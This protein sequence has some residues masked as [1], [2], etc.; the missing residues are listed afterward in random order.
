[1]SQSSRYNYKSYKPQ[2][3]GDDVYSSG[4]DCH[5]PFPMKSVVLD[6]L[7]RRVNLK[8]R[9][10]GK[11]IVL[12]T[13]SLTCP[14]YVANIEAMNS[15]ADDFPEICFIVLYVR[16]EN[17]GDVIPSVASME[18]KHDRAFFLEKLED[19]RRQIFADGLQGNLHKQ[20][21]TYPNLVYVI[22]P[23]GNVEYKRL[24]NKPGELRSHLEGSVMHRNQR[25]DE[26]SVD[27]KTAFRVLF[28]AG[29]Q[30]LVNYIKSKPLMWKTRQE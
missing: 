18:Q 15:L 19:E 30:A 9:F 5:D 10:R 20:I 1:M 12:E 28:R 21:G 7:G 3:W 26:R 24:W 11:Q 17:P 23:D 25:R 16:E 13:G 8:K 2:K 6:N 27:F 22:D 4:I 29:P 14:S